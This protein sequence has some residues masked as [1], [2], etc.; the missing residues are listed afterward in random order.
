MSEKEMYIGVREHE[1][2]TTIKVIKAY[3]ADKLDWRPHE[4]SNSAAQLINTFIIEELALKMALTGDVDWSKME[5]P[6]PASLDE[7]VA[8]FEHLS[9]ENTA[10]IR[11]SD[12]ER[13]NDTIK[14]G[15]MDMRRGQVLWVM[16]FDQIHH[17]GQLSVYIRPAG[18]KV[19]S[20]YGPSA[21]DAG[22][23]M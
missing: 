19:P 14:F 8:T 1:L 17:R 7:M 5:M 13:W 22:M 21:D 23:A 4:K 12:P 6:T 9:T 16:L 3:P 20:I 2:Q 15:P 11:N 10:G 18:G